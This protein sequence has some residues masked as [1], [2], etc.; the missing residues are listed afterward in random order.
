MQGYALPSDLHNTPDQRTNA[1]GESAIGSP[2]DPLSPSPP[3]GAWGE[4]DV[5][6][7]LDAVRSMAEYSALREELTRLSISQSRP[8]AGVR[9]RS[10]AAR[11]GL[12]KTV[13]GRS[14]RSIAGAQ[15]QAPTESEVADRAPRESSEEE[16]EFNV[17]GFL[18]DG[19]LEKR[20]EAGESAKKV[21]VVYKNLTVKGLGSSLAFTKTLPE[22]IV[23][24]RHDA[25][26]GTTWIRL[27]YVSESHHERSLELCC[28]YWRSHIRWNLS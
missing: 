4:R 28:C 19:H 21:G 18:R 3:N 11:L 15:S 14:R 1:P 26:A 12:T 16:E 25:S 13:T 6:A 2:A 17:G 24:R 5:G 23:G 10:S 22:A 7:P 20:T 27:Y 9:R 8:S